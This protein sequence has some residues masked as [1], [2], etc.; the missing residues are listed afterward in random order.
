MEEKIENIG[1]FERIETLI[2][3]KEPTFEPKKKMGKLNLEAS[4]WANAA[5]LGRYLLSG[6]SP[7]KIEE[8]CRVC[9]AWAL[10]TDAEKLQPSDPTEDEAAI[11]KSE[12]TDGF[13]FFRL[14]GEEHVGL[15][16]AHD[17]AKKRALGR[18]RWRRGRRRI[19]E[20]HV[21][22]L[23]V[24][25]G[26]ME[27]IESGGGIEAFAARVAESERAACLEKIDLAREKIEGGWPESRARLVFGASAAEAVGKSDEENRAHAVA[28]S[29]TMKQ[30]FCDRAPFES[31]KSILEEGAYGRYPIRDAFNEAAQQR[32]DEEGCRELNRRFAKSGHIAGVFEDK[33][34]CDGAHRAAA[35][36]GYLAERFRHVEIDDEVDLEAYG[37][38][39]REFAERFANGEIPRVD[40]S[41]VALRFR[42]CGRHRAIGVY[43]PLLNAVAVDPR[44]PRS[45]LHEF[46]HAYD[47]EHGQLSIGTEFAPILKEYRDKLD[48][49]R[50]SESK[51]E[52]LKTPTEVFA[53]AWEVHAA[54]NSQGG[55]FVKTMDE[56]EAG[57]EYAPL[58]EAAR[59]IEEY[60]GSLLAS[61]SA[62]SAD[63]E[64][65]AAAA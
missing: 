47:F 1:C 27:I 16:M 36:G 23:P 65:A 34:N 20:I 35:A 10:G 7:D 40:A 61:Q 48:V 13:S 14:E 57:I 41:R 4:H 6:A 15:A 24:V 29:E 30:T 43:A 17:K 37:S 38:L 32:W 52:Y 21:M 53:R 25:L 39:Q 9:T 46:A 51:A 28:L 42:K 33:K 11:V 12:C 31:L 64:P 22:R 55:S 62:S 59:A 58:L 2:R 50:M 45:L 54:I 26:L 19:G 8:V 60:F 56:Y 5:K 3:F 18:N 63:G 49:S 44:A